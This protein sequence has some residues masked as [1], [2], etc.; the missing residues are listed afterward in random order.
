MIKRAYIHSA[1]ARLNLFARF[2][3]AVEQIGG[4]EKDLRGAATIDEGEGVVPTT[5]EA[6]ID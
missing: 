2:G 6:P 4:I 1:R 5:D 3:K